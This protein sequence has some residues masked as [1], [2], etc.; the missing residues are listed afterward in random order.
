MYYFAVENEHNAKDGSPNELERASFLFLPDY[1][2][3]LPPTGQLFAIARHKVMRREKKFG[4]SSIAIRNMLSGCWK[5]G[6]AREKPYSFYSS[7]FTRTQ[8]Y[9]EA[10]TS[11]VHRAG[12]N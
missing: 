1:G 9:H 5:R 12:H 8:T 6:F 10:H 7:L 11:F 4:R 3:I 2:T